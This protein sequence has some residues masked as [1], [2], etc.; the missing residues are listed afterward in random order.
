MM[1]KCQQLD[2]YVKGGHPGFVAEE[3]PGF[4]HNY[5]PDGWNEFEK[6]AVLLRRFF[7]SIQDYASLDFSGHF[8][9]SPI[10]KP[11]LKAIGRSSSFWGSFPMMS[12][13]RSSGR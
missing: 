7:E 9:I 8:F 13:R 10:L 2:F 3:K 5:D 1:V 6:D 4:T 12:L 11:G